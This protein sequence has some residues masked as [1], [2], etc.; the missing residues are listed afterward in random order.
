MHQRGANAFLM[1]K[2]KRKVSFFYIYVDSFDMNLHSFIDDI[3]VINVLVGFSERMSEP[4]PPE[5]KKNKDYTSVKLKK[6]ADKEL[7]KLPVIL[8]NFDLVANLPVKTEES[9]DEYEPLNDNIEVQWK[10][11]ISRVDSKQSLHSGRQGSVESVYKPPSAT[12]HEEEEDYEIYESITETVSLM[13]LG[14]LIIR[15]ELFIN[16]LV[17]Y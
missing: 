2:A 4:P 16:H 7:S 12:S 11:E 8:R 3:I 5:P 17:K 13:L 15:F 1:N 9:E 6:E 14:I 10:S